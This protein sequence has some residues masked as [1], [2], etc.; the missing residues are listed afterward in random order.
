[1]RTCAPPTAARQQVIDALHQHTDEGHLSFDEFTDRLDE[2]HR[3][4][5]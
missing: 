3:S 2:L 4:R 1:M 5:S